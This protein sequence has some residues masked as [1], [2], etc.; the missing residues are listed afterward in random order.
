MLYIFLLIIHL[1]VCFGLIFI[2]LIQSGRG[3]GLS[4]AF[5]V[6]SAESIFGG[7]GPVGFLAKLT[8]IFAAIF[9]IT[10]LAL[11]LYASKQITTSVVDKLPAP[12]PVPTPSATPSAGETP[13]ATTPGIPVTTPQGQSSTQ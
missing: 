4:S 12:S 5:G 9:I 1:I 3:A 7:R 8:T 13:S 6:G 2:V 10:S 11:S